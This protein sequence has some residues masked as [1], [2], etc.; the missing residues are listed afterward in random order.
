MGLLRSAGVAALRAAVFT[1]M[2]V[3][4][5][6][7]AHLAGG[8]ELPSPLTGL[9]LM[10]GLF[11]LCA[12]ATYWRP[13]LPA[14]LIILSI[15]Q[16]AVHRVLMHASGH[17][18][19]AGMP[20]PV[21]GLSGTTMMPLSMSG[22]MIAFHGLAGVLT[23]LLLTYG[24]DAVWRLWSWL[25]P[26]ATGPQQHCRWAGRR[27]MLVPASVAFVRPIL[28]VAPLRGPPRLVPAA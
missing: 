21:P 11:P 25:A 6:T 19:M 24:E 1:A 12:V 17:M 18:G 5:A 28:S 9:L 20:D 22:A 26:I 13:G 7:T 4:L 16:F 8:G 3:F 15:G 27:R 2:I 23:A 10:A 14:A